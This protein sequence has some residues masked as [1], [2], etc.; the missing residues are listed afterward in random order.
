MNTVRETVTVVKY[1][2][3]FFS[4]DYWGGTT[5]IHLTSPT[6][7]EIRTEKWV[8]LTKADTKELGELLIEISNQMED[9]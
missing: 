4:S 1:K 7:T 3:G 9:Y 2:S 5:C 8:T 6:M